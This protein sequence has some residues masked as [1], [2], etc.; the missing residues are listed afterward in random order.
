MIVTGDGLATASIPAGGIADLAGNTNSASTSADNTVTYDTDPPAL[1]GVTPSGASDADVGII[2]VSLS[3]DEPMDTGTNASPTISDLTTDPY[4]ISGSAWSNGDL[5]WTGT[6]AFADDNE[7]AVGTYNV[8]GFADVAGNVMVGNTAWLLQINTAN[9]SA[10]VTLSDPLI[11]DADI[12]GILTVRVAFD[13]AMKI[14][15][16]ADPMLVFSPDIVS[17]GTSTLFNTSASW[18]GLFD[19]Y[20]VAYDMIDQSVDVNSVIVDVIGAKNAMG[21][22]QQNYAPVHECAID[23]ENPT[24]IS[25]T[26]SP[27]SISVA[28]VGVDTFTVTVVFSE[29]MTTDG[30]SDLTI[31]FMP[32]LPTALAF[33]SGCWLDAMTYEAVYDVLDAGLAEV[34][35]DIGVSGARDLA[36]NVQVAGD[37]VAMF[38]INTLPTIVVTPM[39]ATAGAFLDRC[40][41]LTEGEKCP[42]A[43]LFPLTAIYEA[44]ELVTGACSMVDTAGRIIRGSYVHVYIYSVNIDTQPETV[45]L[46]DH[47]TVHYDSDMGGYSFSWNTEEYGPGYY[48]IHLSFGGDYSNTRRIQLIEPPE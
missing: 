37:A 2:L 28:D 23:T 30:S 41:E 48:D 39:G 3:F 4:T 14:D 15:G 6:F 34:G 8:G 26:A 22:V 17:G 11:T 19:T 36:G 35:V 7:R 29:V 1:T 9:P 25:L 43:G 42:M 12:G 16:S 46:L 24:T 33:A 47:W 38:D 45:T 18:S 5:T 44:C 10:T 40:L 31:T 21:N 32:A 13:M 20:T 27:T